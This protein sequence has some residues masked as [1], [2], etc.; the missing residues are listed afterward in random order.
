MN[1]IIT[2]GSTKF[3]YGIQNASQMTEWFSENSGFTGF[4]F[5]GRSNVG[6]SSLINTLYG[7]S[8]ARTS[9]TPG[10][11]REINIFSFTLS[12]KE[13][14]SEEITSRPLYFFDL[15]GYGHAEVSKQM[16][17][18]W[19]EMMD[20]FFSRLGPETLLINLQD[21]RHPFQKSDLFFQNFVED[22]DL[23]SILVFNKIDKLKTQKERSQLKKML[24]EISKKGKK[25]RRLYYISAEKKTGI[26]ALE[27]DLMQHLVKFSRY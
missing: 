16:S 10:R 27:M 14:P 8:T 11:T 15:P 18:T 5:A 21:A 19:N 20:V 3:R 6:K 7:K 26:D 23:S 17:K 24:P 12:E 4:V 25:A 22:F 1:V 2:P 9:K 13:N